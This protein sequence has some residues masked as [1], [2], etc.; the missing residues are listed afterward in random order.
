M[1]ESSHEPANNLSTSLM[2]SLT[3]IEV[4]H[5]A[6]DWKR[7]L[8]KLQLHT[9]HVVSERGPAPVF[10]YYSACYVPNFDQ[11]LE[12]KEFKY[13]IFQVFGVDFKDHSQD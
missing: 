12:L 10:A 1:K 7:S 8:L 13:G 3:C 2:L 6:L 11:G 4:V 9:E 5:L